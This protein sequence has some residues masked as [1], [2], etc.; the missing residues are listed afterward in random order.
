MLEYVLLNSHLS[1]TTAPVS[2]Q[3]SAHTPSVA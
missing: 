2:I 3:Q 1:S